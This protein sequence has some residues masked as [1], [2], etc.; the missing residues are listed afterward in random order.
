MKLQGSYV[1]SVTTPTKVTL[2]VRMSRHAMIT[3]RLLQNDPQERSWKTFNTWF[4]SDLT[5]GDLIKAPSKREVYLKPFVVRLGDR[6]TCSNGV[7]QTG[8]TAPCYPPETRTD[9]LRRQIQ[10]KHTPK[11]IA[12]LFYDQYKKEN[13]VLILEVTEIWTPCLLSSARNHLF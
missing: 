13:L 9:A 7:G 3:I 8:N 5:G 4:S 11:N 12:D 10:L 1:P 6:R 2:F